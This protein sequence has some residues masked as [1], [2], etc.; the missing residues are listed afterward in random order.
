MYFMS[1]SFILEQISFCNSPYR[2]ITIFS[3]DLPTILSGIR[4]LHKK[5]CV[6]VEAHAST[7]LIVVL[8]ITTRTKQLW[9]AKII[10]AFGIQNTVDK[11]MHI[12]LPFY[13]ITATNLASMIFFCLYYTLIGYYFSL[14]TV[15]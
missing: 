4:I 11:M 6:C 13:T 3:I 10:K 8:T 12:F 14:S 2:E 5:D 7:N 1:I 9:Y 15:F